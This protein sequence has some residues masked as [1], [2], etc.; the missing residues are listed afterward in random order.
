[1]KTQRKWALLLAS[2]LLIACSDNMPKVDVMPE[3]NAEN[4]K[5]EN[6]KV[7]KERSTNQELYFEFAN[8]C[9]TRG[10]FTP[11]KNLSWGFYGAE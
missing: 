4:C 1:M 10:E 6:L 9:A 8:K 5:T 11:S 7:L 2:M 3:V